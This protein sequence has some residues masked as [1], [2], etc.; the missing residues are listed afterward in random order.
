MKLKEGEETRIKKVETGKKMTQNNK[1]NRS[2]ELL[3]QIARSGVQN[4]AFFLADADQLKQ[5]VADLTDR[6]PEITPYFGEMPLISLCVFCR[7]IGLT[8][9]KLG[10][11]KVSYF[12][13][14]VA[15]Y[16]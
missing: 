14:R 2:L 6:F 9:A 12:N 8:A 4:S 16:R 13:V 11:A 15:R 10:S 3:S 1:G 5:N 7:R